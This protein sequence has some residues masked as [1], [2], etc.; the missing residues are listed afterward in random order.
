MVCSVT[1]SASFRLNLPNARW[2]DGMMIFRNLLLVTTRSCFRHCPQI[3]HG[4]NCRLKP[5]SALSSVS[6]NLYSRNIS[7]RCQVDLHHICVIWAYSRVKE[8]YFALE[9]IETNG[10]VS[11]IGQTQNSK[12]IIM[13]QCS[14]FT[15]LPQ[16]CVTSSRTLS[17][18]R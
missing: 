3:T 15:A 13:I 18:W 1:C 5:R 16:S 2:D 10:S 4:M 14:S 8:G 17:I 11:R 9:F 6:S 7:L 12:W